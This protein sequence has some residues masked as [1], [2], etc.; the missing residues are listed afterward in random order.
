MSSIRNTLDR[1]AVCSRSFSR[2]PY[3]RRLLLSKFEHVKFNDNGLSL[4]GDSLIEFLFEADFAITALET[5]DDYILSNLPQLKR[6]SKYGVGLDMVD[7]QAIRRY[8]KQLA[9]KGGVNRRAVAELALTM[10]LS[11]IRKIPESQSQISSGVWKQTV[12]NTLSEKVVGIIG[13]GNIGQDLVTLLKPFNCRVLV[14]DI[15]DYQDFYRCNNL[16]ARTLESLLINSDIVTLHVPLDGTTKNMIS[17]ERLSL[18]KSNSILINTARG[19]LIDEN[20]LAFALKEKKI[21]GAG[22]DVFEVEPPFENELLSCFEVFPT[23]HI[24]GSAEE[25]IVAMGMAAI[26]GLD[27]SCQH[28]LTG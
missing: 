25:A 28:I 19:G 14:N 9:W 2:H 8:D 20:A 6:I 10:M 27:R 7:M 4:D 24:G 11:I 18:M 17:R 1:V 5:I 3:L 21:A 26:D 15:R 16:E 12:G 22:L 23:A 13:C